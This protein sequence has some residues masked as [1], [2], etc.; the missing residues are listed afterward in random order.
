MDVT[1]LEPKNKV[2]SKEELVGSP[3]SNSF[4]TSV[5]NSKEPLTKSTSGGFY[6]LFKGSSYH[7]STSQRKD[8]THHRP[9]RL[10]HL[11]TKLNPLTLKWFFP[12][13][14][15]KPSLKKRTKLAQGLQHISRTLLSIPRGRIFSF[16]G[17][18]SVPVTQTTTVT[19]TTTS[20]Y[21]FISMLI[22]LA[23]IPVIGSPPN[24]KEDPKGAIQVTGS[25][26]FG[27]TL[28]NTIQPANA[29][30]AL[31]ESI[32]KKPSENQLSNSR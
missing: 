17:V 10:L 7:K 4:L 2:N 31:L 13:R 30:T 22:C 5:T 14:K 9:L 12:W 18:S 1:K 6:S 25:T 11:S 27:E 21:T 29:E 15:T 20:K 19:T 23:T 16:S 26:L 3:P 24:K 28:T 8:G 32:Q